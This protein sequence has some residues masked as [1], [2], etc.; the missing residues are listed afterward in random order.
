MG[1]HA[2]RVC[3]EL[4][5]VCIPP[6]DAAEDKW[7]AVAAFIAQ[8]L[9]HAENASGF[10]KRFRGAFGARYLDDPT[11]REAA[12]PPEPHALLGCGGSGFVIAQDDTTAIKVFTTSSAQALRA[13]L[14]ALDLFAALDPQ[15]AFVFGTA[16][17][18]VVPRVYPRSGI[19]ALAIGAGA[20]AGAE[21]GAG[22][23]GTSDHPDFH[24]PLDGIPS[25]EYLVG[26]RIRRGVPLGGGREDRIPDTNDW[27]L[28][29]KCTPLFRGLATMATAGLYLLDIKPDNIVV[30][31]CGPSATH[32]F[33]F[34]DVGLYN[35]LGRPAARPYT[36]WPPET[37][38][39]M[40]SMGGVKA[41]V[42]ECYGSSSRQAILRALD[43]PQ[44]PKDLADA[45]DTGWQGADPAVRSDLK[46]LGSATDVWG[47]GMTLLE[48]YGPYSHAAASSSSF[49]RAWAFWGLCTRMAHPIMSCRPEARECWLAF[50]ELVHEVVD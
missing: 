8:E 32:T 24:D 45:V 14:A 4:M 15:G 33:R 1:G 50:Q 23:H 36:W 12:W 42:R 6:E 19:G 40:P 17:Y 20:G 18:P 7:G 35:A 31:G 3:A 30:D 29:R 38:L 37:A 39:V 27:A 10:V 2:A 9:D 13:E 47:L 43:L 11:L 48:A 44:D 5:E 22:P 21:A 16:T 28:V 46:A 49:S 41:Q 34:V 25:Y 26:V